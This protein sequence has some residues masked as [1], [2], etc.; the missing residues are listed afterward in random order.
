MSFIVKRLALLHTVSFS[1]ESGTTLELNLLI[2]N[3]VVL[4]QIIIA[5]SNINMSGIAF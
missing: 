2:L 1:S 3:S 4:F 5:E